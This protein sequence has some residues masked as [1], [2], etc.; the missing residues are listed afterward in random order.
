MRQQQHAGARRPRIRP[1]G[2]IVRHGS[3]NITPGDAV[4][5]RNYI[6]RDSG[7]ASAWGTVAYSLS[8]N[9]DVT[10]NPVFPPTAGL[11]SCF[12]PFEPPQKSQRTAS[13][14]TSL[15]TAPTDWT[16]RR[17]ISPA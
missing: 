10:K 16:V 9:V 6:A 5:S 2:T 11:A 3:A 14:I 12:R 8:L 15:T 13:P 7:P 1:L 17:R 4:M